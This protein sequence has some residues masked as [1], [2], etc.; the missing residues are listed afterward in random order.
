[1]G[2]LTLRVKVYDDSG[3]TSV[4]GVTVTVAR[5]PAAGDG[6]SGAGSGSGGSGSGGGAGGSGTGAGSGGGSGGAGSGGAGGSVRDPFS[7]GLSGAAIQQLKAAL[8]R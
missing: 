6:G 4:K 3:G 7:V 5:P 8:R 1:P 2:L